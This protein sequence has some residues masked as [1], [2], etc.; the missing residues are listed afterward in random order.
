MREMREAIARG[1][2]SSLRSRVLE[3]YGTD[4][5]EAEAEAG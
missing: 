5:A 2:F 4:A 1:G 3:R